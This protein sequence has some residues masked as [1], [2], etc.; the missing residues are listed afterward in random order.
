MQAVP[1]QTLEPSASVED[2]LAAFLA[3]FR[4]LTFPVVGNRLGQTY[5]GYAKQKLGNELVNVVAIDHSDFSHAHV[6]FQEAID[7]LAPVFGIH[8]FTLEL[9]VD[10]SAVATMM[11]G[12]LYRWVDMSWASGATA[13]ELKHNSQLS[14]DTL[15]QILAYLQLLFQMTGIR[16]K[17]VIVVFFC[18]N[19]SMESRLACEAVCADSDIQIIWMHS[20]THEELLDAAA[21]I[22]GCEPQYT[23]GGLQD[24]TAA[25][26]AAV[27]MLP[28]RTDVTE[29]LSPQSKEF[30]NSLVLPIS[31]TELTEQMNSWLSFRF[32]SSKGPKGIR[33]QNLHAAFNKY[34][35]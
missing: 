1:N 26:T 3:K 23:P 20:G 12:G 18:E 2:Q 15:L 16:Y 8:D 11:N 22:F 29:H 14:L 9:R 19:R 25:V 5:A 4:G 31:S 10:N 7:A 32:G 28:A 17:A 30:W 27:D 35:P 34:H 13:V 6:H 21:K 24:V 33:R